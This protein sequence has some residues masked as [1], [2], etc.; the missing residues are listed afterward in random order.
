MEGH[1]KIKCLKVTRKNQPRFAAAFAFP[2]FFLTFNLRNLEADSR[3]SRRDFGEEDTFENMCHTE[4]V[5]QHVFNDAKLQVK[6]VNF[7]HIYN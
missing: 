3:D 7:T 6:H 2:D 4:H 1:Q 5:M